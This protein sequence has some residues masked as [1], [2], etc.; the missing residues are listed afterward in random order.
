MALAAEEAAEG[1]DENV[2]DNDVGRRKNRS[3]GS[4]R[5]RKRTSRKNRSSLTK[6]KVTI[7]SLPSPWA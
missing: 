5:E 3:N 7:F 4:N 6:Y 2:R 1:V